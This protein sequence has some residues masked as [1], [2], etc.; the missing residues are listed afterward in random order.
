MRYL[1]FAIRYARKGYIDTSEGQVHYR[2]AGRPDA[3][4]VLL[5]HQTASSSVMYE[6]VMERLADDFLL[7]APDTPGYGGTFFP[8][9]PATIAYYA[10]VMELALDALGWTECYVFGHHTGAS[11]AVQMEYD[12]PG[13]ARRMILSG[14]PYLT[15]EQKAAFRAGIQPIVVQEDG[16][17]AGSLW[18]RLRAKDPHAPLWLTQREFVL[19]LHVGARYH[20]TYHAVFTHD[21]ETQLAALACP[22]LV[23]AGDTD[24]LRDSLEPAYRALQHGFL[25][26][27]TGNTYI[28]DRDPDTVARIIRDFFQT[29]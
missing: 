11:I 24:T 22:T 12:R 1:K 25:R 4:R 13:L 19:N 29:V 7:F 8:P 3:P 2:Q 21:F 17:H 9:A 14:P 26:R 18:A 27:V 5:L 10:Q 20:E 6:A 15:P 23:M 28:C 16:S